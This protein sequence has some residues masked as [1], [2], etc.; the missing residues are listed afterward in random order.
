MLSNSM[1]DE[2]LETV[3]SQTRVRCDVH[4]YIPHF[5]YNFYLF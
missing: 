1:H 3:A 2:A 4:P 5:Y